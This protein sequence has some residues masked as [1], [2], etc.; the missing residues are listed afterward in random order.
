LAPPAL[1][2]DRLRVIPDHRPTLIALGQKK[3][4]SSLRR[5]LVAL[6]STDGEC[7]V[8]LEVVEPAHGIEPWT[9]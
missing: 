9:C 4:A 2:G 5:R 8:A 3:L 1:S 6:M 7:L